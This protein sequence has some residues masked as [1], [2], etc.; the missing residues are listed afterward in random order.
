M[1]DVA[2][3]L[4]ISINQTRKGLLDVKV[5]NAIGSLANV[6][7]RALSQGDHEWRLRD[8]EEELARA[9]ATGVKP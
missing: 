5:A 3:L 4:A 7:L 6:L 2:S 1:A 9:K 8:I